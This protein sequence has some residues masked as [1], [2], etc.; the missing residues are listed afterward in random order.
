MSPF[1]WAFVRAAPKLPDT[2]A[3]AHRITPQTSLQSPFWTLPPRLCILHSGLPIHEH[4]ERYPT[5]HALSSGKSSL[6]VAANSGLPERAATLDPWR[7]TQLPTG[8]A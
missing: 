3:Y 8:E 2:P 1:V 5:H 6:A 4:L 7:P